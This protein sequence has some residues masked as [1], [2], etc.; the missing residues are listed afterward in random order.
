MRRIDVEHTKRVHV[1]PAQ[2]CVVQ[3][4]AFSSLCVGVSADPPFLYVVWQALFARPGTAHSL[5]PAG[6][7]HGFLPSMAGTLVPA[8]DIFGRTASCPG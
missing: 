7:G 2:V 3:V 4:D 1:N 8:A 6:K 5:D